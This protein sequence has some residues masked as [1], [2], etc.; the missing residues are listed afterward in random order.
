[1]ASRIQVEIWFRPT[2]DWRSSPNHHS[3]PPKKS[4]PSIGRTQPRSC[5]EDTAAVAKFP[6]PPRRATARKIGEEE[7]DG[8]GGDVLRDGLRGVPLLAVHGQGPRLD[9]SPP[10]REGE[11]I[12][13]PIRPPSPAGSKSVPCYCACAACGFRCRPSVFRSE[14]YMPVISRCG[15]HLNLG[16]V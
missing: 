5:P 6:N 4:Q 15:N 8:A 12:T 14:W 10:G 16:V 13:G 11:V 2:R 1:M 3:Q 9:R 7:E